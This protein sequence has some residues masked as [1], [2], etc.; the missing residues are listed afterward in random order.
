VEPLYRF[1]Q[2]FGQGAGIMLGITVV[3]LVG[4]LVMGRA[5]RALGREFSGD[6]A[7]HLAKVRRVYD[8]T[9]KP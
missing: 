2:G 7:E 4:T 6:F 8:E 9:V 3:G 5:V 1:A